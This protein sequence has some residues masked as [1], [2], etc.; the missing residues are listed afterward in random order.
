MYL[1]VVHAAE[2]KGVHGLAVLQHDI[3]GYVNHI[4]DGAHAGVADTLPHPCGRGSYLHV[5]HHAG[6]VAGAELRLL[7]HYLGHVPYIALGG[8]LH[9]RL[10]ELQLLAEGD[11]GFPGQA[12]HAQA[13]RPVGGYLE[14][15]H[16]VV[17]AQDQGHIVPGFAVLIDD[18]D[19]VVYAVGELPLLGVKV[20]EGADLVLA[21]IV[22]QQVPLMDVLAAGD[23]LCAALAGVQAQLVPGVAQGLQL[24]RPGGNDL[25]VYL[26]SGLDIWGD[27][28]L[29]RVYGVVVPQD[30][31]GF[32]HGIG[33]IV[34]GD[35]QLL[36]GAEHA[37]G[38][39]APEF[40]PGY[41]RPVGKQGFVEGGGHQV[42]HVDVPGPGAYLHRLAAADVYTA[43]QHMVGVG[44]LLY[45]DDAPHFYVVYILAQIL[46]DF[47]LGA[48]HGHG[49]GKA[50]VV[51]LAEAEVHI[52]VKP[53]S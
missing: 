36:Q 31:G 7:H 10:M 8:G 42:P 35:V 14:L 3:V 9:H 53:F 28:G 23:C 34:G 38:L 41:L 27:G 39:H 50:P 26:V 2:V 13:V 46:G 37:V 33:E 21:G 12:Y 30:G 40:A 6:G 29:G 43:H 25:A 18:E 4:V 32:Y 20:L 22:G 45:G 49:L 5:A 47:H 1:P 15:H 51:V 48:G 19:A 17:H 11:G 16:V 24:L 44:V 52:F